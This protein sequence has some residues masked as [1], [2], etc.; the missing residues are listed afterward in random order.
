MP[1]MTS[2][3]W[4]IRDNTQSILAVL[5]QLVVQI[6]DTTHQ[7]EFP[8]YNC[9][10]VRHCKQNQR[11][12]ATH[13]PPYNGSKHYYCLWYVT[14]Y[15]ITLSPAGCITTLFRLDTH[16]HTLKFIYMYRIY[17]FL[18][19]NTKI[20]NEHRTWRTPSHKIRTSGPALLSPV[21]HCQLASIM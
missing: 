17:V 16:T 14:V 19:A 2:V 3:E 21:Q 7:N 15:C 13:F 4:K 20:E 11:L 18:R 8:N 9:P 1:C 5:H 10:V 6:A 12:P